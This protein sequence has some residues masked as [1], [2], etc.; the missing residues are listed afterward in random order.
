VEEVFCSLAVLHTLQKLRC[1]TSRGDI[2]LEEC[3]CAS[4]RAT[5]VL[6]PI[7]SGCQEWSWRCSHRR[8]T[9][10][11]SCN[12]DCNDS[13]TVFKVEG[14]VEATREKVKQRGNGQSRALDEVLPFPKNAACLNTKNFKQN[15]PIT[16][17]PPAL[18]ATNLVVISLP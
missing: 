1:E 3:R 15:S 6:D 11:H 12:A 2:V 17:D 16:L 9:W 18:T 14:F 8:R 13:R 7:S 4:S 10:R 5:G